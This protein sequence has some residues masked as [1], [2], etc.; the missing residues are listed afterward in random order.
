MKI[1]KVAADVFFG[2]FASVPFGFTGPVYL[3]FFAAGYP[4]AHF[5]ASVCVLYIIFS[6]LSTK[7]K[8]Y[9]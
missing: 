6:K 7:T 3:A 5:L 1:A 2:P 4:L 9:D 8:I